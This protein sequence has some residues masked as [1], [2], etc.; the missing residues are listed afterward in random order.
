MKNVLSMHS[1]G[2]KVTGAS[3]TWWITRIEAWEN[4]SSILC[5]YAHRYRF[6][7]K[8]KLGL[9]VFLQKISIASSPSSAGFTLRSRSEVSFQNVNFGISGH[10]R[11][12][13]ISAASIIG[14]SFSTR[15][16]LRRVLSASKKAQFRDIVKHNNRILVLQFEMQFYLN[17]GY[18]VY[19]RRC[20]FNVWY[21]FNICKKG[22]FIGRHPKY[23]SCRSREF[24]L[25]P[26][27]YRQPIWSDRYCLKALCCDHLFRCKRAAVATIL[28]TWLLI[29][30][31]HLIMYLDFAKSSDLVAN[32]SNSIFSIDHHYT[33]FWWNQLAKSILNPT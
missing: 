22:S 27:L 18:Q 19:V 17:C 15:V 13:T 5:K 26:L 16:I 11:K 32:R 2:S 9:I 21:I 28:K 33:F 1:G 29:L 10:K 30:S 24:H 14:P 6:H 12:A 25:L 23:C 4:L 31:A 7:E 3:T 20:K 8:K